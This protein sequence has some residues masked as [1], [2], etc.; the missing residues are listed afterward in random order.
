MSLVYSVLTSLFNVSFILG[1]NR[2]TQ[3]KTSTW[4]KFLKNTPSC[5]KLHLSKCGN[6]THK[7]LLVIDT[8]YICNYTSH[9]HTIAKTTAP[10]EWVSEW[11]SECIKPTQQFFCYIMGEQVN[12]RWDDK[13]CFVID[14]HNSPRIDMS[15]HSETLSDSEP[16]SLWSYSLML[17]A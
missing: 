17:R 5:I 12:F 9:Y 13:I 2:S 4:C 16:T 15:P 8:T 6:R 7:I 11:V 1:G 14:Q 10:Y 3:R